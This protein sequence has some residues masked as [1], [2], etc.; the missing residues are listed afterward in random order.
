MILALGVSVVQSTY[1]VVISSPT[2]LGQLQVSSFTLATLLFHG[3]FLEMG[4]VRTSFSQIIVSDGLETTRHD[5][6]NRHRS[7]NVP[8]PSFCFIDLLR[9]NQL[10]LVTFYGR[11]NL[12]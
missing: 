12:K 9:I 5:A 2:D 11:L 7:N 10:I 1:R 4:Q 6:A 3:M 8:E